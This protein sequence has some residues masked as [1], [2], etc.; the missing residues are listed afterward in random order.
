M[1]GSGRVFLFVFVPVLL[2]FYMSRKSFKSG[3]T[4]NTDY[5]NRIPNPESRITN[6]SEFT[7]TYL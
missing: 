4:V 2:Y 7:V 6:W 3:N 5:L 1:T